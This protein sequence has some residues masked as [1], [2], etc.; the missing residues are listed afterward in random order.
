M[1]PVTIFDF[2]GVL[3]DDE[4]V[5][6][7]AIRDVV[8]PMGITVT[9]EQYLERYFGSDD[10]GAFRAILTDVGRPPSEADVSKMVEA[11]R[12]LYRKRAEASLAIFDGAADVVRRCARS[13]PVA[14]VS[15]A[16]KD[17][18]WFAL[19][20]LGVADCISLVVSAEDTARCK[21]D[22][23]GYNLAVT[24]LRPL[25]GERRAR[26][27]LVIEDS[28]AGVAAAKSAGLCCLAVEHSYT[29]AE[30]ERAGADHVVAHIG[31]VHDDL[32]ASLFARLGASLGG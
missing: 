12:P 3:V 5:H 8:G 16:L 20:K 22:P 7:A 11:K 6:L 1:F 29:R 18:I 14:I 24:R 17:E 10:A 25:V 2:N 19:S 9:D 30:L 32:R 13:G 31:D 15:G 23:E 26:S 4:W 28:L 21:P 27:S